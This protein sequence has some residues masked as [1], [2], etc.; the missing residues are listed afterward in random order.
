MEKKKIKFPQGPSG[1]TRDYTNVICQQIDIDW[2]KVVLPSNCHVSLQET[3]QVRDLSLLK[4]NETS[5][6][7][8]WQTACGEIY[9]RVTFL[10]R[11]FGQWKWFIEPLHA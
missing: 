7:L 5:C 10:E 11:D 9:N 6:S 8:T 4:E 2:I 3:W 1:K